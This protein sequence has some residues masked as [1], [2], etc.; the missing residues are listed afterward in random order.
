MQHR[1]FM[2]RDMVEEY[3]VPI[4]RHVVQSGIQYFREIKEESL[5]ATKLRWNVSSN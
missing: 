3:L 4:H 1:T 5:L 2:K